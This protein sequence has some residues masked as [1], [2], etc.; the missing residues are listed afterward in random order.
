[1]VASGQ[2]GSSISGKKR[3]DP[4]TSL[5]ANRLDVE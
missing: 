5:K 1:M 2:V 4:V 3:W